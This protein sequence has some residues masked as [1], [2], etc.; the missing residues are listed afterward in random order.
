M[1]ELSVC[2]GLLRQVE[3]IALQHGAHKV[4]SIEVK[5]G[6]LSGVEPTLL[7]QAFPLVSE[8]TIAARAELRTIAGDVRVRCDACGNESDVSAARLVCSYCGD[9][10]TRVISGDELVLTK[11]ELETN[12]EA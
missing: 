4:K 12:K 9:W 2:Q 5:V 7:K 10:H 11:V 1:H 3:D 8:S 6:P